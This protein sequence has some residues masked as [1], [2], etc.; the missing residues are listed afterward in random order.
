MVANP[1]AEEDD[2]FSTCTSVSSRYPGPTYGERIRDF[3]SAVFRRRERCDEWD[4]EDIEAWIF[5]INDPNKTIT[6][7]EIEEEALISSLRKLTTRSLF[8]RPPV[9]ADQLASLDPADRT[10]LDKAIL[11]M[12]RQGSH[13]LTLIAMGAARTTAPARMRS[14]LPHT[15]GP[16]L[17]VYFKV[18]CQ[19]KPIHLVDPQGTRFTLPYNSCITYMVG[20]ALLSFLSC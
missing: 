6:K 2:S 8:N 7:M 3:L 10:E 17:T 9:L 11:A 5:N 15:S 1:V 20:S 18:G 14:W 13:E 19:L 16:P 4:G 12:K